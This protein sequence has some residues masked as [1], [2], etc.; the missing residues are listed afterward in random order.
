[1]AVDD[2]E[3]EEEEGLLLLLPGP[4]L[5]VVCVEKTDVFRKKTFILL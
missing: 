3:D 5:A 4:P 2:D 1:M